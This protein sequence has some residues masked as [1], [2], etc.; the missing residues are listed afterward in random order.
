MRRQKSTGQYRISWIWG[1]ILYFGADPFVDSVL[2][3]AREIGVSEFFLIQWAAPFLS[4][5]PESLTAFL[6]ALTV[7]N[8]GESHLK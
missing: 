6:W 8:A 5:F 1:F 2:E 4:E 7:V 3:V